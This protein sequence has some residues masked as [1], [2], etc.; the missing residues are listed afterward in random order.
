MPFPIV[1]EETYQP[2]EEEDEGM[3][4][5]ADQ[6][7]DGQQLTPRHGSFADEDVEQM[8]ARALNQL[9]RSQAIE[10]LIKFNQIK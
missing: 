6:S 2:P 8:T 9:P 1:E 7:W 3:R 4:S 10:G 5:I